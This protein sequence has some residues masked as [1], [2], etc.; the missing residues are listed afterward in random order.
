M[1][2]TV[3]GRVLESCGDRKDREFVFVLRL[4]ASPL[5]E[6]GCEARMLISYRADVGTLKK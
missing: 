1:G 6:F 3:R 5:V 2:L 4:N